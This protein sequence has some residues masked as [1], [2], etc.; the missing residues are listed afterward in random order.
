MKKLIN[1]VVGIIDEYEEEKENRVL[2][3][4]FLH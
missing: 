3:I 2:I 1:Q 4:I